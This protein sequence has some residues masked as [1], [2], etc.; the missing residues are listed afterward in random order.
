MA[1]FALVVH[2]HEEAGGRRSV[3]ATSHEHRLRHLRRTERIEFWRK[4]DDRWDG[5]G[6]CGDWSRGSFNR[7]GRSRAW[8]RER[9]RTGRQIL[10]RR[11]AAEV[12]GRML[13]CRHDQRARVGRRLGRR[14][15]RRIF[16]FDP[17][18]KLAAFVRIWSDQTDPAWRRKECDRGRV[19]DL[20]KIKPEGVKGERDEQEPAQGQFA[21]AWFFPAENQLIGW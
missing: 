15:Q 16:R 17:A 10:E 2:S 12:G 21:T 13:N 14:S 19:N 6:D 8:D 11:L 3:A 5:S 4:A 20:E 7:R 1:D 9:R 18:Q